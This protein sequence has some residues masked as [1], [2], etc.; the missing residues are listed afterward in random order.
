MR[1]TVVCALIAFASGCAP[2]LKLVVTGEDAWC[3]AYPPG[4]HDQRPGRDPLRHESVLL[5]RG[6]HPTGEPLRWTTDSEGV[7]RG[8]LPEGTWCV[9]SAWR[10]QVSLDTRKVDGNDPTCTQQLLDRCDAVVHVSGRT[11]VDFDGTHGCATPQMCTGGD[12]RPG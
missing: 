10:R 5:F 1:R 3:N 12:N 11:R 8:P 6:E 4:E 9:V 7:A 2:S